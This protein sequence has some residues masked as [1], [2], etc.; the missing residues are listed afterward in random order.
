MPRALRTSGQRAWHLMSIRQAHIRLLIRSPRR[1]RQRW[2]RPCTLHGLQIQLASAW[3]GLYK[4][5]IADNVPV[6]A[7]ARD[8][9]PVHDPS[10]GW[11]RFGC[12]GAALLRR[13]NLPE[14]SKNLM[15]EEKVIIEL[16]EVDR[17]GLVPT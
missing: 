1:R 6:R 15:E 7:Q 12:G 5:R 4:G 2:Q 3:R 14:R 11:T 17:E 10:A 13:I 9:G 16:L 8:A